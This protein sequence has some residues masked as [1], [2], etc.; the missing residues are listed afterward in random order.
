MAVIG[1][2][3]NGVVRSGLHKTFSQ[4]KSIVEPVKMKIYPEYVNKTAV[5][6]RDGFS[7]PP[8]PSTCTTRLPV[9]FDAETCMMVPGAKHL[10]RE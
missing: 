4:I 7:S 2:R 3:N 9:A 6:Q 1:H 5:G 10:P 8:S